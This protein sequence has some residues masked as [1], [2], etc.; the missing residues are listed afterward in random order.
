MVD[1]WRD[2]IAGAWTATT[3]G[4][5]HTCHAFY[6]NPQYLV[7]LAPPT[8]R[9]EGQRRIEVVAE[10]DKETPINVRLLYANGE[11]VDQ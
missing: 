7:K 11:R 3:A 1:S 4:G 10:T 9:T 6:R 2:Q 5:N 8:S